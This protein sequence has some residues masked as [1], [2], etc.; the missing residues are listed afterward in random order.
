MIIINILFLLAGLYVLIKGADF[1]IEGSTSIAKKYKISPM[2]IGLT[3]VAF[4]TS[5]PELMINV[6]GALKGSSGVAMGN[7]IGSNIANILLVLGSIALIKKITVKKSVLQK[8]IPFAIFSVLLLILVINSRFL[9][10]EGTYLSK[11]NGYILLSFFMLFMLYLFQTARKPEIKPVEAE[12]EEVKKVDMSK[13][14]GYIVLGIIGLYLGSEWA[15]G[16]AVI[17]SQLIGMSEFAISASVIAVGT[18]LPELVTS[19][20]AAKNNKLDLAVGNIVGSNIF[21]ILWILG[22][23]SAIRPI[24][25]TRFVNLDLVI[26]L[27]ISIFF[28]LTIALREDK[29]ITKKMG[30]VYLSI[31]ALYLISLFIRN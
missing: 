2:I 21:N 12:I 1:L 22:V 6:M 20:S 25:I 3:I 10:G 4:G 19:L 18:S 31:Y 26:L 9:A 8:E 13:S 15:V 14:A 28:L 17:L 29:T 24:A 11:A 27:A 16:N 23:T 30:I 5:M 7:V